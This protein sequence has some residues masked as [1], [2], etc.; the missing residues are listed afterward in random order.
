MND[1]DLV[2]VFISYSWTSSE[3]QT[4]VLDLA[5]SLRHDG[6]DVVLD[7]WD[8]EAGQ[9]KFSFM[10]TMVTDESINRVL[11]ILD[12]GYMEK[13]DA[14]EGGVG[15]ETQ[16]ITPKLYTEA[17][18]I[19]FL[20]IVFEKNDKGEPYLPIF[21]SNRLYIDLSSDGVDYQS[22]YEQ[23]LR[24]L[25]GMPD[26]RKPKLGK[27]PSFLQKESIDTFEIERKA[28]ILEQSLEKNPSRLE[29]QMFE[30]LN[31]IID[32]SEKILIVDFVSGESNLLSEIVEKKIIEILPYRKSFSVFL[33]VFLQAPNI[34]SATLINFFEE[35][36]NKIYDFE[37]KNN[38]VS[39]YQ[40]ES[41]YFL[42]HELFILLIS[43][44]IEFGKWKII[45][46]ILNY[47]YE[48]YEYG[49][50]VPYVYF[51]RHLYTLNEETFKAKNNTFSQSA[52]M[53]KERC[54]SKRELQNYVQADIFLYYVSLKKKEFWSSWFPETYPYFERKDKL[55]I[56]SKMKS[57]RYMDEILTIFNLDVDQFIEIIKNQPNDK[58]Y[59]NM[60]QSIPLIRQVINIEKLGSIP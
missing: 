25:Y 59:G 12:R 7:K 34:S 17:K 29:F 11:M 19:K 14:R 1:R 9:D 57:K 5:K 24:N 15:T 51:R 22:E 20:P 26:E 16:I 60:Y 43:K 42:L 41:G 27:L 32:D 35:W 56:I 45:R 38:N 33:N 31:T 28:S 3:H 44:L 52:K 46:E 8:L 37:K 30:F 54:A 40:L 23:L 13:A 53:Q 10:E 18:S 36:N 55:K 50:E 6:I 48:S 49:R 2:R 58:G 21:V 47:E 4:R 39:D